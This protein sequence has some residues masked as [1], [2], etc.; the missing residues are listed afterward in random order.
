LDNNR[1]DT[2][3]GIA[4][5][6]APDSAA[7]SLRNAPPAATVCL[8]N[9]TQAAREPRGVT[10]NPIPVRLDDVR[11]AATLL[12]LIA[13]CDSVS[14]DAA[15]AVQRIVTTGP[16]IETNIHGSEVVWPRPQFRSRF[17][18]PRPRVYG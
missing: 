8:V 14:S 7:R 15:V 10:N 17:S 13:Q 3:P 2:K 5:S 11:N 12:V 16:D 18:S 9:L 1:F 4:Y 6:R